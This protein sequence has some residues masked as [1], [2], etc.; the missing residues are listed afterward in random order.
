MVKNNT[1]IEIVRST[2]SGL[3]SL[4]QPSCDAIFAV[5]AKHYTKVGVT[6]VNNLSD[7]EALVARKPDLVFLGMEYILTNSVSANIAPTKIWVTEYL[8]EKGITYTG[9]NQAAHEL[10][11]DKSLAKRCV[12]NA[13]LKTS[14]FCV[15]KQSQSLAPDDLSLAFPLFIKPT[16]RGGGLGIDSDSVVHTFEQFQSKIRSIAADL[17]SDSLVEE[18]LPGREFSVAILKD[19]DSTEFSV[20]PL[21]LIAPPDERGAR[22]LSKSVKTLNAEQAIAV[23]DEA[24]KSKVCELAVNVFYALGARDYGRVD[25]R[26]DKYGVPH[27]LEANLIPS[28]ISGYGSFPKACVLN[29][30]LSYESM[31]LKIVRLGLARGGD[32]TEDA[33]EAHTANSWASLYSPI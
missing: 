17:R 12:L 28:L 22:I 26:L 16:S 15:I 9:S 10:G 20:M 14:A 4:S 19:E 7:L 18:Y 8:D 30:N 23:A 2:T 31:I 27:F 1:H 21:E 3:S 24:T 13:G 5:L 11:R 25:I 6:I 29:L 33:F 32:T